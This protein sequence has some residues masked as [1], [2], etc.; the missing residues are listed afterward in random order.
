LLKGDATA[1]PISFSY[2]ANERVKRLL[3]H[4]AGVPADASER[5]PYE[6]LPAALIAVA[7]L[8]CHGII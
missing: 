2:A 7:T 1:Q 5:L 6:W 4:A 8:G 3:D